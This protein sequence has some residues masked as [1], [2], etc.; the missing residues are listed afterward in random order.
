L[1]VDFDL[2]ATLAFFKHM[3]SICYMCERPHITLNGQVNI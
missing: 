1:V 2:E 3:Y